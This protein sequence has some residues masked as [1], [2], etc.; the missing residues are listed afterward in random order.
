MP[1][2]ENDA[3][4]RRMVLSRRVVSRFS[5]HLLTLGQSPGFGWMLLIFYSTF[6]TCYYIFRSSARREISFLEEYQALAL[7]R[8]SF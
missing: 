1:S 5:Y 6:S 2:I 4:R 3:T 8:I 7:A